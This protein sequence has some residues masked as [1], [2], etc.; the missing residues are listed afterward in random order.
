MRWFAA[1]DKPGRGHCGKRGVNVSR[2]PL[3]PA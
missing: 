3:H 2:V 1:V